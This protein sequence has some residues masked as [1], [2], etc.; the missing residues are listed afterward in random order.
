MSVA[1]AQP[2]QTPTEQAQPVQPAQPLVV[3]AT[4][5]AVGYARLI[6]DYGDG[7]AGRSE[8]FQLD[9]GARVR[10]D[11]LVGLH[12]GIAS[13]SKF[14]EAHSMSMYDEFWDYSARPIQLGITV[15]RM[16]GGRLWIAPW[17]GIQDAL[18]RQDCYTLYDKRVP[19]GQ[20]MTSCLAKPWGTGSIRLAGGVAVSVD[21][22]ESEG[23]RLEI[24]GSMLHA[25][26]DDGNLMN[27][28]YTGFWLGVGYRFWR[29]S[30]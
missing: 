5:L 4:S 21:L 7:D 25:A 22:V 27:E 30:R 9:V 15:Q 2:S 3:V 26:G 12:L 28:S 23:H 29:S 1:H 18:V 17:L 10:R 20:T 24:V 11:A 14:F 16:F 19:G 8:L 6:D 13:T